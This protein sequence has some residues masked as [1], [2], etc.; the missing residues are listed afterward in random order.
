MNVAI[1]VEKDVVRLDIAVDDVL[2]V[3]VTQGTAEL[4]NPETDCFFCESLPGN[5]ESQVTAAH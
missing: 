3:N 5:M 4:C 1:G 2:T